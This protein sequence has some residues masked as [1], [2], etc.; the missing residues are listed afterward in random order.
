MNIPCTTPIATILRRLALTGA[1]ALTVFGVSVP[2]ASAGED[3]RIDAK[4]GYV[5]F[6]HD[7]DV[8]VAGDIWGD[9]YGV[10]AYLQWGREDSAQVTDRFS[11]GPQ[12][13]AHNHLGNEIREGAT[14]SLTMCY[15]KNGDIWRCSDRQLAEA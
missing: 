1:L 13:E 3:E 7:G 15:T 8:L 10:R 4:Y 11:S 12:G 6:K 14:V 5:E 2:A 9:G